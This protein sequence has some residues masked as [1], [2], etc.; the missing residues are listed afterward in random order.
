[1]NTPYVFKKCNKCGKWLVVCKFNFHKSKT[2]KYGFNSICKKCKSRYSKKYYEDN[3]EQIKEYRET[4]REQFKEYRET[5][6]E[7]I[8]KYNKKYRETHREQIKKQYTEYNSRKEVKERKKEWVKNNEEKCKQ[9]G[10]EWRK[11]NPEKVLNHNTKRRDVDDNK[12]TEITKEQYNDMIT[13]FNNT[14][15]VSGETLDDSKSIDHII[16]LIKGGEHVIWNLIPIKRDYN[17]N[18]SRN[19][20]YEWYI[21]QE[22]FSENRLYKIYDWIEYAKEKYK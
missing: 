4:H 13:F 21:Q 18:K 10:I 3:K 1:M 6:R 11:N 17:I 15:A 12:F 7:Q 14:C 22:Y 20:F 5:H 2:K 19:D 16:P 8:K 9:V